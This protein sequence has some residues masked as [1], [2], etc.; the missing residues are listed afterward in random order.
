L[1]P[2]HYLDIRRREA[3]RYWP[4]EPI[5]RLDLDVAVSRS[6]AY[7]Q[8]ILKSMAYR[9][10]LMM[11]VT[12]GTDSRTIL[13]ASKDLRGRIYYFINNH[14]LG[15][16]HPDITVPRSMFE[17]IGVPFH[18]HDVPVDMDEEFKRIYLGNTF[19][20]TERLLTTIYNVYFRNHG[21][22]VNVTATGEIGRNRYGA[23]PRQ[24]NSYLVAYKLGH[25]AGC[26]YMIRQCDKI[27]GELLPVARQF[28]VNMLSLLYWEQMIGNWGAIVNSESDIAI[29]EFDPYGSHLLYELF[30]GVD[31]RY[32]RYNEEPCVLF[33]EMIRTTWPELLEWPINPPHTLRERAVRMMEKTGLFGLLKEWKYRMHYARYLRRIRA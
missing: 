22:K 7:L 5:R 3:R 12:S 9:H 17:K 6:C 14:S 1:L 19:F 11:A 29:E 15:H 25:K 8:G 26:R 4:I 18:I 21:E 33:R 31:E 32:A 20:R 30:L 2:N 16:G 27:L 13:A 23:E 24:L 10:P 28:G